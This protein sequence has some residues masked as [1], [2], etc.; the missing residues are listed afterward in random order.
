MTTTW[1]DTTAEDVKL[2]WPILIG[3][4]SQLDITEIFQSQE[5]KCFPILLFHLHVLTQL[6]AAHALWPAF[7]RR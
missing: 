1:T 5:E 3:P 6:P 4:T 2:T 7:V